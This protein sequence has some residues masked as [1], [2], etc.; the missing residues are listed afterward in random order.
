ME[1]RVADGIIITKL[2]VWLDSDSDKLTQPISI[3][4]GLQI[5]EF[6]YVR[7]TQVFSMKTA[8]FSFW[9]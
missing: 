9:N 3:L 7:G 8:K 5:Q 1:K 6:R 4:R 2:C